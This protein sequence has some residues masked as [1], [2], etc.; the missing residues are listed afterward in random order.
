M[1]A[2][3]RTMRVS[4]SP[5]FLSPARHRA[6]RWEPQHPADEPT[7]SGD[8]PIHRFEEQV[9]QP[10]VEEGREVPPPW[11]ETAGGERSAGASQ[12][13]VVGPN[14]VDRCRQVAAVDESRDTRHVARV[15]KGEET[16]S[17][18][19]NTTLQPGGRRDADP[20]VPVEQQCSRPID[21]AWQC[22]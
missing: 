2:A 8:L 9:A 11:N 20:A 3:G 7:V 17:A 1:D 12:D 10:V 16:Q 19:R 13:P 14:E 21:W 6:L 22:W 4:S 18:R 5:G 15:A